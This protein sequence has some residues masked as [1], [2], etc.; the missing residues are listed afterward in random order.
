[1]CG[2]WRALGQRAGQRPRQDWSPLRASRVL[3]WAPRNLLEGKQLVLISLVQ[4]RLF[5][6]LGAFRGALRV[7]AVLLEAGEV[8]GYIGN[9]L[10]GSHE[11]GRRER[12][13]GPR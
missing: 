2:S 4:R 5:R 3:S 12:S 13:L 11:V 9:G 8:S 7:Q 10:V 1:M 6:V